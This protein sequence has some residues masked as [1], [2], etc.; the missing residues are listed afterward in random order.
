[1]VTSNFVYCET[2]TRQPII[3]SGYKQYVFM[4]VYF[5]LRCLTL[6]LLVIL[7]RYATV[8]DHIREFLMALAK[9]HCDGSD[10]AIWHDT[11]DGSREGSCGWLKVGICRPS[12][13]DICHCE[14]QLM[15]AYFTLVPGIL[16]NRRMEKG[17]RWARHLESCWLRWLHFILFRLCSQWRCRCKIC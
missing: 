7:S 4:Y 16:I 2:L 15:L 9:G 17:Q 10:L 3:F 12:L 14:P 1:M 6:A 11:C 8:T 5:E 13:G